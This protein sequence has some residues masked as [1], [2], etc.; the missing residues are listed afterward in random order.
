MDRIEPDWPAH[1][2]V[3]AFSTIRSG[4][5]SHGAWA[6][7]NLGVNSGDQIEAVA[8]NRA[9]LSAALPAEPRWLEQVHGRRVINL[10]DWH[11]GIEADAAWTS[12]PDEVVVIQSADCLPV[13]LAARDASV[14]AGIHAGWRSLAAG[15]ITAT[16]EAVPLPAQSLQAWFGPGICVRCYP[17][18]TEL[19]ATFVDRDPAL[20]AAF[21]SVAGHWHADLKRIAAHQLGAAG[22]EVFD[23]GL[24][25]FE[26][27]ERFFSY[28]RDGT[29]G[30]MASLIWRLPGTEP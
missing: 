30:R 21:E 7:F 29:T 1:P 19:R 27:S 11:P 13:L 5:F 24:C 8:A 18:G 12:R 2:R 15:I 6:S 17:V 16:L 9:R 14:V 3:R 23:S 26:E 28:R 10:A 4:G 22:V 20:A 25:S